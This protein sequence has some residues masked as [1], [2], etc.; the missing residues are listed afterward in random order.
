M[1]QAAIDALHLVFT[2]ETFGFIL[3][4]TLVGL[5]VGL[6]PALGG[7][8]GM[9]LLIPFVFA[10]E[11]HSAIAMLVGLS[12]VTNTSDTLVSVMFGVP[13]SSGA[14]AT[15]IDGHPM[16]RKG[17]AGRALGAAY[18]ASMIGGL[19]GALILFMVLPFARSLILNLGSPELFMFV[20]FGL[21]MVGT[22]VG[23]AVLP[24]ITGALLGV[25][26]GTVGAAPATAEPRF[27]FDSLYLS[28]GVPLVIFVL[29]LYAIPEIVDLMRKGEPIAQGATKVTGGQWAG[30]RDVFRH[31][32]PL[33]TGSGVGVFAGVLPGLGGTVASWIS[34]GLTS[35]F[36]RKNRDRFGK[37]DVRGVIA[38]EAANNSNDGGE[39]VPTLLFGI[40]GSAMMAV[41]LGVLITLGINPGPTLM[42]DQN[43]SIVL[44]IVWSLVLANVVATFLMMMVSRQAIKLTLLDARILVPFVLVT[45]L[46]AAY[47]YIQDWTD[48]LAVM[49]IGAGA[50]VIKQAGWPRPPILVG[51]VL[52]LPAERYLTISYGRYGFDW[53]DRPLV[54][55]FGVLIALVILLGVVQAFRSDGKSPDSQPVVASPEPGPDSEGDR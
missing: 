37:G 4:G 36:S 44:V 8:V 7:V 34:Y 39:L 27:T 29:G 53:L 35:R 1:G 2:P 18:G 51:F 11:P 43:L 30:F 12:A 21:V 48:I 49:V 32:G 14:A 47:Q 17:Q 41:V 54:I 33:L 50:W 19:I 45:V 25:L 20:L 22:L 42:E 40:P 16:A 6:V 24:G 28:Q 10:M 26:M 55:V 3:L 52:G 15:I 38:P 5:C 13:G 31:P 9:S 46:L 23:G